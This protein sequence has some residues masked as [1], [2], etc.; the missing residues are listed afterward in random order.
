LFKVFGYL[1]AFNYS[2][3]EIVL[4]KKMG[5]GKKAMVVSV[6]GTSAPIIFSLNHSTPEYIC[7]FASKETKKIIEEEILPE[8]KFKFRHHD[9]IVT[10]N[11][12]LLSECYSQLTKK[13]PEIIEKWELNPEDICVDYTGGTKTMTVALAMATVD[14][15]CCYSY[16]G[17]GQRSKGGVGVVID[18]N[19]RMHFLD[20]PWDEIAQV[21][22]RDVSILFNKA[23]YATAVD[24]LEKCVERVSKDQKPLFKALSEMVTG[25]DLWDRFKHPEARKHLYRCRETLTALSSERKE[26]KGLVRQLETNIQFLEP[27]LSIRKPSILHFRDLLANAKRRADLEQKYDDAVARLYRAMEVLAQAILREPYGIDTSNVRNGDIPKNLLQEFQHK[28]RDEKDGRIKV[29]LF[30]AYRLL[31]ELKEDVAK[32]FFDLY[33]KEIKPLLNIR[34]Q[35][36]LAHGFNPVEENT[37]RRLFDSALKV[38]GTKE[39]DLPQFPVLNI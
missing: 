33:E 3:V 4:E 35:S 31:G 9:W 10:P 22:K 15:S 36:I 1:D 5:K 24:I 34:N 2:F 20:N 38:S 32:I 26:I 13:L 30:A 14:Q 29:P 7:F 11:A 8:L 6:G 12:E 21:E 23:R 27:L 16:V 17:G 28:Y 18:G 39:E 19:E 25:Y 37:F